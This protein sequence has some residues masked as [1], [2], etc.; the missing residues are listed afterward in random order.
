MY[1]NNKLTKMSP[2]YKEFTLPLVISFFDLLSRNM[3]IREGNRA[4]LHSSI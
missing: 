3:S 2:H 1:I 4:I